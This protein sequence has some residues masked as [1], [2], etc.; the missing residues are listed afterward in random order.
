MHT[1][2]IQKNADTVDEQLG[3]VR[4]YLERNVK[5]I[6]QALERIQSREYHLNEQFSGLLQTYRLKQNELALVSEQYRYY[7]RVHN[8]VV[9]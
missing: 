5:E 4:P 2:Q 8:C 6:A 7:Q 3:E 9:Q 1:E